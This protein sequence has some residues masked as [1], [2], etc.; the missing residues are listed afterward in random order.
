MDFGWDDAKAEGNERKHGVSFAEAMTMLADP[1]ALTGFDPDHSGDEDR[2]ITMRFVDRWTVA[3]GIAY[4]A[5]RKDPDHQCTESEP[6]RA[7]GLR[8]WQLP[9]TKSKQWTTNSGPSTTS[10]RCAG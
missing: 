2:Y 4:R 6:A 8:G 3:V 9:L 1:L 7:K 5:R 10:A